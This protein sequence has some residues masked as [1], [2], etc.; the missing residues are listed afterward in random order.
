MRTDCPWLRRCTVGCSAMQAG[1][2]AGRQGRQSVSRAND[3]ICL[4]RGTQSRHTHTHTHTHLY[5]TWSFCCIK[6]APQEPS[7]S[8]SRHLSIHSAISST[9]FSQTGK[10]SYPKRIFPLPSLPSHNQPMHLAPYTRA[11]LLCAL[12]ASAL[13]L[14]RPQDVGSATPPHKTPS[15]DFP[16]GKDLR[17]SPPGEPVR[18]REEAWMLPSSTDPGDDNPIVG[19]GLPPVP[20]SGL[21]TGVSRG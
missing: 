8:Y 6:V 5:P 11:A 10:A 9:P 15:G 14:P 4:R 12:A 3:M 20:Q 7:L 16:P 2:Q 1:R 19:R 21:A 13:P 18:R 17:Q